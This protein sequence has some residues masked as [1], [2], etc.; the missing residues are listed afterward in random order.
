MV[1]PFDFIDDRFDRI[2]DMMRQIIE[3]NNGPVISSPATN[4]SDALVT[5]SE[6]ALHLNISKETVLK[7][8]RNGSLPYYKPG[9]A[10]LFKISEVNTAISSETPLR[11]GK[12][13]S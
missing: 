6:I 11:R 8:V 5:A 10:Y 3:L 4:D 12:K 13:R 7:R 9:K 2:E 1:N